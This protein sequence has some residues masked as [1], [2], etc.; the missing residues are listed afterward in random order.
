M[1]IEV[2]SDAA[3]QGIELGIMRYVLATSL[4]FAVIMMAGLLFLS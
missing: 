1:S 4:S 2:K 3:R